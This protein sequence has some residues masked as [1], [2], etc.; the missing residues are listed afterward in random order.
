MFQV[1]LESSDDKSSINEQYRVA[2][3]S[4]FDDDKVK[5]VWRVFEA[6]QQ[7]IVPDRTLTR[8]DTRQ[9]SQMYREINA[10]LCYHTTCI[11]WTCLTKVFH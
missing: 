1:V 2:N 7:V 10:T 4:I 9:T 6:L 8:C 11:G 5:R 3:V